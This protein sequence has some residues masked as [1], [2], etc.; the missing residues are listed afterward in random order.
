MVANTWNTS[1]LGGQG[2]KTAGAQEF[3]TNLGNM[4]RPHL[5]K[6][7][8]NY[9]S[10]VAWACSPSYSGVEVTELQDPKTL[11]QENR[12]IKCRPGLSGA[13][14]LAEKIV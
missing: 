12:Q 10:M 7:Y 5:Y 14:S 4:A 6:N 2:K 8:K 3:K 13:H 9:L 1:T 11:T